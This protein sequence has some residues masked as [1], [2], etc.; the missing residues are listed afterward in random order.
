M[1]RG[2]MRVVQ[3]AR[4]RG[5]KILAWTS[6]GAA[7]VGGPLVAGMFIGDAIETVLEAIPWPWVA[8]VILAILFVI[9]V[10]DMVVDW[11][12]NHQAIYS[13]LVMPSVATATLGK[14]GDRVG[15]WSGSALDLIAD[16][17][18][19]ELGTG[20]PIAMALVVAATAILLAQR[21]IKRSGRGGQREAMS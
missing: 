12:P 9:F 21:A 7:L 3:Q 19:E 14:L 10:R 5:V 15:E 16:P 17:L 6:L 11:E 13:L 1:A 20:S 8:P 4:S 18:R 2:G